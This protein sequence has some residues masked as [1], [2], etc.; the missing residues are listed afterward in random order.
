MLLTLEDIKKHLNIDA[1]FTEDDKYLRELCDVAEVMVE[2][3]ID[4]PLD[5]L[6]DSGTSYLP[7]PILHAVKL[8]IGNL[9]DNRESIAFAQSND[10]PHSLTS[11]L[12]MYRDY[13]NAG[14]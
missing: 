3:H 2:K 11:I 7:S 4:I 5:E 6:R 12:R 1:D 10:L 8:Y 14:I 9:Y 13:S